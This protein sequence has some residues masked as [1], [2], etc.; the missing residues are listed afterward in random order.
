M[1]E[2]VFWDMCEKP[3]DES[4]RKENLSVERA[5]TVWLSMHVVS[6]LVRQRREDSM[7]DPAVLIVFCCYGKTL[8]KAF[9]GRKGF[10]ISQ[11]TVHHQGKPRQELKA[12]A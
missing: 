1:K 8:T 4:L 11:G 5:D 3:E 7:A 2:K 12:G 9:L 6:S 10:I